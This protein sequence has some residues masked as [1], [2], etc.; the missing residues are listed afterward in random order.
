VLLA[1]RDMYEARGDVVRAAQCERTID[2]LTVA[3]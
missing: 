3:S 1:D 2:E